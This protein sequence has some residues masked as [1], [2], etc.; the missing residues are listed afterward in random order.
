MKESDRWL[1]FARQDLRMAELA[2]NEKLY[3]QSCFHAQQYVEK[4]IK[5]WLVHQ[6][7]TPPRNHSLTDLINLLDPNPL[8]DMA[9]EIQ[10]LDRVY[11]PTRYPDALPGSLPE[12]LPDRRDAEQ[13]FEPARQ[14]L[15]RIEQ[16][17]NEG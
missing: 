14:A 11:I 5:A 9:F 8:A 10:L 6:V 16:S 12:G 15:V 3:N 2:L 7:K 13:A 1:F 4:T 17:I